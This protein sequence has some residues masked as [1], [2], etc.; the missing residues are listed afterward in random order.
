MDLRHFANWRKTTGATGA[1]NWRKKVRFL[2]TGAGL[3]R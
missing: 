2:T 3:S 1:V